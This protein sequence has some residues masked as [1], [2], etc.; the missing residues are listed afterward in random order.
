MRENVFATH[1]PENVYI[2]SYICLLVLPEVEFYVDIFFFFLSW[3]LKAL[4][5]WLLASSA[6]VKKL[7][8][9]GTWLAQSA[10]GI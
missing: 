1:V 6:T 2:H 7:K 8:V 5:Y 9:L 4:F 3:L 10:P